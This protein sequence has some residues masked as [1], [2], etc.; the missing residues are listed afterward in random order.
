MR[1]NQTAVACSLGRSRK[2]VLAISLAAFAAQAQGADAA[3]DMPKGMVGWW[4][5]NGTLEQPS[6]YARTPEEACPITAEN[7]L[8]TDLIRMYPLE[9]AT[10]HYDCV[11]RNRFGGRV[12][13]YGMTHLR[14]KPG[15]TPRW[16]GVCVERPEIARPQTCSPDE[17]GYANANPVIVSS[18]AKVQSEI[19]LKAAPNRKLDFVRT[20][21]TLRNTGGAQS[22]G[23]G[24]SFSFDRSF[25]VS[26]AP[27][28]SR[29]Y[30]I[31]VVRGD[32]AYSEF[33]SK[34]AGPYIS[35]FERRETLQSLNND[36]S[37]WLF[38]TAD[39][40]MDRF[41]KF[42][43]KYLLVSSHSKEGSVQS[44][45]YDAGHQL[46]SVS[47]ASGRTLRTTWDG[48]VLA[49]VSSDEEEVHYRYDL[50]PGANDVPVPGTKRL[51]GV[52]FYDA[53]GILT[54]SRRYHYEH[55]YQRYL[56]TGIT[57]EKGIRFATYAYNDAGQAI[58][59]EHAGGANRHTFS[60]PEEK[61]RAVTDPLG[62]K[63][64]FGLTYAGSDFPGRITSTSQ[65]AGAGC[66]AAS[67][68]I[69]YDAIGALSSSTDFNERKTCFINDK[70]RGLQTS[71][72][73]GLSSAIACPAS[74][75][76][77]I[78]AGSRRIS[79]QWNPDWNIPSSVAGPRQITTYVYNGQLDANGNIASCAGDAKL[80]NGK[81]IAVLCVKTIQPTRDQSGA[82]GFAAALDGRPRTWRYDYNEDGQLLK[83]IGPSDSQGQTETT[84]YVYYED[85][86]AS[87]TKDDLQSTRNATGETTVFLE[88]TKAGLPV[89]I[90]R[91]DGVT[92]KLVYGA[93]N[94]LASS[95][96][97]DGKG[98]AEI[99]RYFYE[100]TG[101]LE[102][103][104]APDGSA[105][106]FTYDDAQRLTGMNDSAGNQIRLKLDT[107]GN[108]THTETRNAVGD[109]VSEAIRSFDALNRLDAIQDTLQSPAT[110]FQYDRSGNVRTVKDP[111]G[112]STI[113]EFDNFDRLT[114]EIL[115]SAG[116][117]KPRGEIGYAYDHRDSL[118]SVT[119]PRARTTHYNIDGFGQQSRLTSPDTGT[120]YKSYDDAGKLISSRDARGFTTTYRYDAVGRPTQIGGS[121]FTYGQAGKADAGRLIS[122]VDASGASKFAYDGFGRLQRKT[123]TV[124]VGAT[125][126]DFSVSYDYGTSGGG[127]GHVTSLTY[128]SGNRIVIGYGTDGRPSQMSLEP[129]DGS[130]ATEIMS[131]IAHRPFGAAYAW[132]WGNH[133]QAMPNV[134]EKT[135]DARGRLKSYPLGHPAREGTVRTLDY[136]EGGRIRRM[137][138]KGL[139]QSGL[140]DQRYSYDDLDRLTGVDGANLSQTFEYDLNGNRTRARFGT[141]SY[142]NAINPASNRLSKTTGPDPARSNVYDGA[143]NLISDGTIK[144]AYDASGRLALATSAEGQTGYFYNGLGQRVAK[145]GRGGV[146][147]YYLY[148]EEG[149][150]LGEYNQSGKPIQETVYLEGVP[151]AVL[152]PVA[153][154]PLE[155]QSWS[156]ELFYVYS[157]HIQT[158][159]AI[160]KASDNRIVWRWDNADPFGLQPPIEFKDGS[161]TFAYNPRYPGQ[162]FDAE[163]N[164]HY[165]YYRDYDPQTGRYVQSDP[166][167]L[168]GGINTYGYAY[169]NPVLRT[170]PTGLFVPLVVAGVCAAG[171]CEALIAA[172]FA[173]AILSTDAGK[174]A[175]G[176]VIGKILD[177]C[178][179]DSGGEQKCTATTG[180]AEAQAAAYAWAGISTDGGGGATAIPWSN[181]NMPAGMSRSGKE[182]GD[183]M[184]EH[185]DRPY[186]YGTPQGTSVTEHPFGHPDQ[187]GPDHHACPHF[188]AR[189][190]AGV[191]MIF[192][193]SSEKSL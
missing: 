183:F 46:A 21:R 78:P 98:N 1:W 20:Y 133:T 38:T 23:V 19:D 114:R 16:P 39:G 140:L 47:D 106:T 119:D 3:P 191:E 10:P 56:L 91:P 42:G 63:R 84:D 145:T 172:G 18:G 165:N 189:N 122:M 4:Y 100:A 65:P 61:K 94:L 128:P 40:R 7:H 5:Y 192:V 151:V 167:G 70:V 181:F 184:R 55:P 8:D 137:S 157:D 80:P 134:Y 117:D 50:A 57:N 28:E 144:Y 149:R 64:E 124:A 176:K 147:T 166:I 170:D 138:H 51:V 164:L 68:A 25:Q 89:R 152:K 156:T 33:S 96:L 123:Q 188:H 115:P 153:A 158:A 141:K 27:G 32:G 179:S 12:W 93:R 136:D 116:P 135:F 36:F 86:T 14:C 102:R 35:R 173:A 2:F 120:T 169:G 126:R 59:S 74:A 72:V 29:P 67:S 125:T 127:T 43:D 73:E 37:D 69:T 6:G 53:A 159:R 148:G 9:T 97:E 139:T 95:T 132:T 190:A 34:N 112:R 171:G 41:Q 162:I 15:F 54:G 81:P 113:T 87:H 111:L 13:S 142:I 82:L 109:L 75:M 154:K 103:M 83:A 76:S 193:Y 175:T 24:W 146:F 58:L 130:D 85:T 48:K 131:K 104:I 101:Q 182:W 150:L 79:T 45:T 66:G 178:K 71:R 177:F 186:G 187:P 17:P 107:N 161:E 160:T 26:I 11:Y 185:Y 60:Y 143:G 129:A 163:T 62:T 49:K 118:V 121:S 174:K 108:V 105:H 90:Q 30:K 168:R 77:K 52:D 88:Y 31:I 44:H 110:T 155:S 22:G 99:T 180:R 92:N